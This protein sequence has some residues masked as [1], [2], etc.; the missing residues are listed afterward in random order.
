ML[1]SS[2]GQDPVVR[3][4]T[5]IVEGAGGTGRVCVLHGEEDQIRHRYTQADQPQGNA[6]QVHRPLPAVLQSGDGVNNGQIPIDGDVRQ[7]ETS[8]QEV[9]L[10]R[11]A[12][13]LAGKVAEQPTGDVLQDAEREDGQEQEVGHGQV[14]QVDLADT[15]E[16][17]AA[18]ED[19]HHQAV[20]HHTQQEEAAI[21]EGFKCGLE[22]P[23][24]AVLV[25]TVGL[26]VFHVNIICVIGFP[27]R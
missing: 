4:D 17:P 14:Q 6:R 10:P 8:T 13:Q 7:Q 11:Q 15:Q 24:S 9:E 1:Q 27:I 3:V 23:Q 12:H 26:V 21:K 5:V 16:T 18:Q 2:G 19:R 25:T 20:S 22:A